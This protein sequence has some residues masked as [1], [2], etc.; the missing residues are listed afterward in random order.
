MIGYLEGKLVGLTPTFTYLDVKGVGYEIQ[1]SLNTYQKISELKETKIFTHLQVR[2]DGWTLYG[3]ASLAEKEAF[4]KLIA[5]NGIGANTAR[6]ML[7]SL[8]PE[9]LYK[10][11][12]AGDS[13]PLEKIKGIGGKTA[14]RIILEL[15]GKIDINALAQDLDAAPHNTLDQDALYALIGLGIA[16][17]TAEAALKKVD[18]SIH[19]TVEARIKEALKNL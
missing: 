17:N 14:Q 18:I 8:T 4:I 2:E 15:K 6:V 13:K 16:K 19:H 7:S 11:I 1:I 10:I 12:A 9:E 5:I 3:F